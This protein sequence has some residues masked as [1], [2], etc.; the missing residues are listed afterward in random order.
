MKPLLLFNALT[1]EKEPFI[2]ENAKDVKMYYCGPTVYDTPHLGHART[3]IFI[4][5]LR[6]ILR[7]YMAYGVRSA[8]NVTDLG[9][10]IFERA[11]LDR[12]ASPHIIAQKYEREFFETMDKL[13]VERADFTPRVTDFLDVGKSLS[14]TCLLKEFAYHGSDTSPTLY[15]STE[16]YL[17]QFGRAFPDTQ[18]RDEAIRMLK[19]EEKK[20]DPRD[21]VLWKSK[22]WLDA[23]GK[24]RNE[25][26]GW[27]TEC[28]AIAIYYFGNSVD[29][30]VG[31]IDLQFPHH[32]N[33]IALGR[34]YFNQTHWV[35]FCLYIGHLQ[36]DGI[37][38][39]KSLKNFKTVNEMILKGYS[40]LAIRYMFLKHPYNKPMTFQEDELKNAQRL[41]NC[42]A[43]HMKY[44]ELY[45]LVLK[46]DGDRRKCY[47]LYNKQSALEELNEV[48]ERINDLLMDNLNISEALQILEDYVRK[49]SNTVKRF[50][51]EWLQYCFNYV[52][53]MTE[54]CF[55]FKLS[56]ESKQSGSL[57]PVL[58]KFRSQVREYAL[59]MK[60]REFL[61]KL[62]DEVRECMHRNGYIV[63]D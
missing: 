7:N 55:G 41:Y 58:K 13:Y 46:N 63:E 49:L 56:R 22:E 14:Q 45:L 40:P 19:A 29:I 31:G 8:M 54:T 17:K 47:N 35:R 43:Y 26:P 6:R 53:W 1:Q 39:S 52:L 25:I 38:M 2:P 37:K 51:Y 60:D 61:L 32:E 34:V 15:F 48:K 27:H 30:H 5:V 24:L 57:Y 10:K 18:K 28:A 42:F 4:D 11:A 50:P 36:M 59:K 20:R 33:E 3:Y 23:T 16:A 21:F 44:I 9:E 12:V 62:C